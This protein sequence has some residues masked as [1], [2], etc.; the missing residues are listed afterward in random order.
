VPLLFITGISGSGK[1]EVLAE[2]RQRGY[3]AYGSDEDNLAAWYDRQTG[4]PLENARTPP[5]RTSEFRKR[6]ECKGHP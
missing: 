4:T 5:E 6:Y 3:E 2:L 1:S